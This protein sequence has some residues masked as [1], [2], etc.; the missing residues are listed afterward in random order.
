MKKTFLILA[1][2]AALASACSKETEPISGS[3]TDR[4]L[5]LIVDISGSQDTKATGIQ[6]DE[7]DEEKVNSLQ[8]F[9][10]NGDIVDG[11]G[12][13]S[14][15]SSLKIGCTAGS[16][17]I[18]ALVNVDNDLSTVKSKTDLLE[19]ISSL[20]NAVS[21]FEMIGKVTENIQ[22]DN[23]PV[24]V[25]VDRFAARIKVKKVTNA[26]TS[27]ALQTQTFT[28]KSIHITNVAGDI[29][30]GKS[31]GYSISKWY[32]KMAL[33]S[34]NNLSAITNDAPNAQVAYGKSY[35]TAHC[36]YSYPNGAAFSASTTWS[37]RASMLVLKVQIGST[38]YNYPITLPALEH[39]KS[40]EIEE[41]KITRPGNLDDGTEGGTDE[42]T[43]VEGRDCQFEIQVNPW[44]VV[45]VSD[46][47][48]KPD[49]PIII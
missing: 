48:E 19:K 30:Y 11:Y 15:A 25:N 46:N 7:T 9:V 42:M 10:F 12:K 29:N 41:I 20:N 2:A 44:T 33:E 1:A 24:S 16:R 31:A 39:N 43:P 37:P 27:P 18:Y 49:D 23:Q 47:P 21:D 45:T 26:L 5:N 36:F 28:I 8:V 13:A 35:S 14:A 4:K 34:Q 38:L 6:G 40:Y 22:T 3:N 32:N 17:E